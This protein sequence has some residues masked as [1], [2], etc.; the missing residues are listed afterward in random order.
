MIMQAVLTAGAVLG[1]NGA[2]F[3][4]GAV[5]SNRREAQR[6]NRDSGTAFP[7]HGLTL[8]RDSKPVTGRA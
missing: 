6:G 1:A 5:I 7:P 8:P 4:A 2:A 3:A